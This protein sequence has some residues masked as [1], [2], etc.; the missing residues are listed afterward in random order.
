MKSWV[1]RRIGPDGL[2]LEFR[3]DWIA[4][5]GLRAL[6]AGEVVDDKT[7]TASIDAQTFMNLTHNG[8]PLSDHDPIVVDVALT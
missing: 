3:L 4:A 2:L 6:T 7:G 8:S 5:R 1:D